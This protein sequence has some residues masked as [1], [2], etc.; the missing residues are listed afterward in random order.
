[1][2]ANKFNGGNEKKRMREVDTRV[3]YTTRAFR[4][5]HTLTLTDKNA[6][7]SL[8]LHPPLRPSAVRVRII[9]VSYARTRVCVYVSL[10]A[11]RMPICRRVSQD[12]QIDE[13]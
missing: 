3:L 9:C 5:V 6:V 12:A 7:F 8:A 13:R 11:S 1:M 4:L 2:R 10:C